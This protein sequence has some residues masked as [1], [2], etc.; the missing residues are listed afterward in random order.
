[1]FGLNGPDLLGYLFC[2][3]GF[4]VICNDNLLQM[5]NANIPESHPPLGFKL[6]SMFLCTIYEEEY[7][8]PIVLE[9]T[10]PQRLK[11]VASYISVR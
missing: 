6:L 8:Q 3:I 9:Q 7:V 4:K 1:M 5:L 11:C 10:G 2:S